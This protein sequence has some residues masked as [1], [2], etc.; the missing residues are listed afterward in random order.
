VRDG[1]P[2]FTLIELLVVIAIIAILIGLLL[3][4]VQKVRAAA[5]RMSCSNNLKQIGLAV[6][7]YADAKKRVPQIWIQYYNP[8]PRAAQL[9]GQKR[10][11]GSMFFFLLPYMENE[12][13][14]EAG[15]NPTINSI[16]YAGNLAGQKIVTAYL[17]P[18]DPTNVSNMADGGQHY[19]P[20]FGA[21][22]NCGPNSNEMCAT[23]LCYAG[24]VLAFDPNPMECIAGN[25]PECNGVSTSSGETGPGKGSL[26]EAMLDGTA[27]TIVF[28][29][30]YKVCSSTVHGT[31]HNLWWGNPR[32]GSGPKQTPGFGWGDYWRPQPFPNSPKG[33]T[34]TGVTSG[35]SF[36]LNS[37]TNGA[38]GTGIP[39]QVSPTPEACRQGVTQS[40]H[41]SITVVGLGDGSTRS[42]G[43]GISTQI[44]YR[45]C[46]PFDG[47]AVGAGW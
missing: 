28:A 10:D 5:Q 30:R 14:F 41:P 16:G 36:T 46:H 40:P 12:A 33:Y 6:H 9:P 27:N 31:T 29:H 17:C 20:S 18:S 23:A 47:N 7:T 21:F 34:L 44:W 19:V 37:Q 3:P 45:L 25:A 4:A 32:N 42:V 38:A 1:R 24:N 11:T 35:A 22:M 39:F 2:G 8:G 43:V 26:G 15:N 13:I